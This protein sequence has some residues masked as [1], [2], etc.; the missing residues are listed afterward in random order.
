MVRFLTL[1]IVS[2]ALAAFVSSA[3]AS[4]RVAIHPNGTSLTG[5]GVATPSVLSIQLAGP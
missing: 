3:D 5:T 2:L 1:T 4:R